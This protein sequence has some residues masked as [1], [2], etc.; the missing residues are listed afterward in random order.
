MTEKATQEQWDL[1]QHFLRCLE[2]INPKFEMPFDQMSWAKQINYIEQVDGYLL[3]EIKL[4]IDWLFSDSGKWFLKN[5]PDAYHLRKHF[6]TIVKQMK[7]S[8]EDT[9]E[10]LKN[11]IKTLEKRLHDLQEKKALQSN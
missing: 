2:A 4:G 9:E 6:K 11:Q 8:F 1:A 5:V 3:S 10:S 7:P